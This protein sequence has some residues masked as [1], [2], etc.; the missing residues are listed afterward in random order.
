MRYVLAA[1]RI[2]YFFNPPPPLTCLKK[3]NLCTY[4]Y[5]YIDNSLFRGRPSYPIVVWGGS[6]YSWTIGVADVCR[7]LHIILFV[8]FCFFLIRLISNYY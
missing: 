6:C 7:K 1:P 3:I 5:I 8:C 2:P 4:G